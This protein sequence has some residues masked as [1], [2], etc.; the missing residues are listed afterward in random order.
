[1]KRPYMAL[2]GFGMLA[3]GCNAVPQEQAQQYEN[4]ASMAPVME[5]S[6]PQTQDL[7]GMLVN[8]AK[9]HPDAVI[10]DRGC[11]K[12]YILSARDHDK[13]IVVEYD[14][15]GPKVN[16]QCPQPIL[17]LRIRDAK[18]Y[19]LR[20]VDFGADGYNGRDIVNM[21]TQTDKGPLRM[22]SHANEITSSEKVEMGNI[23][24]SA[25]EEAIKKIQVTTRQ[26]HFI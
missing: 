3:A 9:F 25:Y 21:M 2:A 16:T 15:A 22:T 20:V 23:V 17:S 1:M 6:E 5:K 7:A 4:Q 12:K 8:L 14:V 24:T 18:G 11:S 26:K 13:V 10:E 19:E